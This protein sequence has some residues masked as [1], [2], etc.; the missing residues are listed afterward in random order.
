MTG[1]DPAAFVAAMRELRGFRQR[2]GAMRWGLFRDGADPA[3]FVEVYLVATWEEYLRQHQGRLTE[4][5]E[6]SRSGRSRWPTARPRSATC[7]LL[8]ILISRMF[9]FCSD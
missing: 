6:R 4:E 5:D 2:T 8:S 1:S 9:R 7:C 3:R